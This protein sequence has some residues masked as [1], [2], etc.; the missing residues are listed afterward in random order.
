MSGLGGQFADNT[1]LAYDFDWSP[2]RHAMEIGAGSGALLRRV[3][4]A[5]RHLVGTLFDQENVIARNRVR[6]APLAR[7]ALALRL[8]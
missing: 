7:T 8:R 3:L 4:S 5:Q 2:Y 1:A 6:T